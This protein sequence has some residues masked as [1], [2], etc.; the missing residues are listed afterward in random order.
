VGFLSEAVLQIGS[1]VKIA[2]QRGSLAETVLE[3][4]NKSENEDILAMQSL[5]GV[6]FGRRFLR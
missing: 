1:S 6:C 4:N 3:S 2:D 5:Q